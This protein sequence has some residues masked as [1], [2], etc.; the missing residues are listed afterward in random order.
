MHERRRGLF[1]RYNWLWPTAVLPL[2][3]VDRGGRGARLLDDHRG[4]AD[5]GSVR[6][7]AG[8]L[9]AAARD[10][11]RVRRPAHLRLA[12]LDHVLAQ[13]LLLLRAA[14][15]ELP[16]GLR[17]PRPGGQGAAGPARRSRIEN[18]VAHII[19]I[20]PPRRGRTARHRLAAGRRTHWL[21]VPRAEAAA[22]L[23]RA[24]ADEA[25]KTS[26][27]LDCRKATKPE[28]RMHQ[29]ASAGTP[30]HRKRGPPYQSGRRSSRR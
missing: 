6:G 3:A 24:T 15:E 8:G 20:T 27:N 30:G 23:S 17:V 13:V 4:G 25:A 18:E 16:R 22:M 9:G 2:Q 7:S 11:R 19:H 26:L 10:G 5:A 14:E 21:A 29:P 28:Q 12:Q 1:P